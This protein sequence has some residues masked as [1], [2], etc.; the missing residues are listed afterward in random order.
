MIVIYGLM[1]I[2]NFFVVPYVFVDY[3]EYFVVNQLVPFINKI[4]DYKKINKMI[5][6]EVDILPNLLHIDSVS[7]TSTEIESNDSDYN[8]NDESDYDNDESEFD[9]T[10]FIENIE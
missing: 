6:I 10:I 7:D 5:T 9:E 4:Y 2:V 3:L 1:T 8:F